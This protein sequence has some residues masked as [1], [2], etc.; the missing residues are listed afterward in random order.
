MDL[1]SF[2]L[3]VD[4]CLVYTQSASSS[5]SYTN[6][7]AQLTTK[8]P[9]LHRRSSHKWVFLSHTNGMLSWMRKVISILFY[10]QIACL[11]FGWK[12]VGFRFSLFASR[13]TL[14]FPLDLPSAY[15]V[16]VETRFVEN[17]KYGWLFFTFL[18]VITEKYTEKT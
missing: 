17:G 13:T 7:I 16:I 4:L 12:F 15:C 6:N 8:M 1:F 3:A 5:A 18:F 9:L 2:G 14:E 10:S 11:Y